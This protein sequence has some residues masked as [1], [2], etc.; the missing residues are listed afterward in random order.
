ME[1]CSSDATDTTEGCDDNSEGKASDGGD[2]E[3]GDRR[4]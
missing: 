1:H 2:R 3:V 4:G